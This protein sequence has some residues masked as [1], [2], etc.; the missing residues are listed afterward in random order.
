SAAGILARLYGLGARETADRE[1]A[2]GGQR[3]LAQ[4]VGTHIGSLIG[5]GPARQRIDADTSADGLENRHFRPRGGLMPLAAGE[6]GTK[7]RH[8]ARHRLNL[9]DLAAGVGIGLMQVAVRV[10]LGKQIP[11]WRHDTQISQAKLL[12]EPIAVLEG[13]SEMLARIEKEHGKPRVHSGY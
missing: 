9:A 4:I 2:I 1:I 5:S 13:F 3:I 10:E 11:A 7:R 12:D 8:G 6:P